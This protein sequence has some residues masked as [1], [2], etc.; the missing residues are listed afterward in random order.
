MIDDG[1]DMNVLMRIDTPI[2]APNDLSHNGNVLPELSSLVEGIIGRD[3]GQN[4]NGGLQSSYQVTSA[5]TG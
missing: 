5:P 4:T 2:E 1:G 3:S